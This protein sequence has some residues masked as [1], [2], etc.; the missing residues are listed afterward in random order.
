MVFE[1]DLAFS[2]VVENLIV[3]LIEDFAF[4]MFRSQRQ[5]DI[6]L[7]EFLLLPILFPDDIEVV[8]NM[9]CQR[10]LF[11]FALPDDL[12]ILCAFFWLS[13]KACGISE[14]FAL[15]GSGS[16]PLAS[17]RNTRHL[18]SHSPFVEPSLS[19]Y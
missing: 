4:I 8:S 9:V 5:S 15:V 2:F 1:C 3:I 12:N 10:G 16:Y 7:C 14:G 17:G 6:I 11:T 13:V 19:G 18:D